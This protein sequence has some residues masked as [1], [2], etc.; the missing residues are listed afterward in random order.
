[1][2][3]EMQIGRYAPADPDRPATERDVHVLLCAQHGDVCEVALAAI[4]S[5]RT[6]NPLIEAVDGVE[7]S[8]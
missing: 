6:P 2:L 1:V 3:A 7:R 5:R 4:N 8:G